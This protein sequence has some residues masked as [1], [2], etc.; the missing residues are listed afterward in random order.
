MTKPFIPKKERA[1][2]SK[3]QKANGQ[4]QWALNFSLH[5]F[6]LYH[7]TYLH[8][9][10]ETH[11]LVAEY[12]ATMHKLKAS[13]QADYDRQAACYRKKSLPKTAAKPHKVATDAYFLGSALYLTVAG[14][15]LKVS[16]VLSIAKL[17]NTDTYAVETL[18]TIYNVSFTGDFKLAHW[19]ADLKS[20][21]LRT[22]GIV[23]S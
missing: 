4:L 17:G 2:R 7:L 14:E 12:S 23:L 1:P 5:P 6:S 16:K 8:T 19:Q 3:L 20:P 21:D 15:F 22:M 11:R 10:A 18:N 13:L 9:S